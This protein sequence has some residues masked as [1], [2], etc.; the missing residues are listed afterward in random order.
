MLK[1]RCGRIQ[2]LLLVTYGLLAGCRP[3][4]SQKKHNLPQEL[5]TSAVVSFENYGRAVPRTG[6]FT[7][8]PEGR[9]FLSDPRLPVEKLRG[10][11]HRALVNTMQEKGYDFVPSGQTDFYVGY[12]A[13]LVG[14]LDDDKIQEIY[15][16][17]TGSRSGPGH[18]LDRFSRSREND[19]AEPYP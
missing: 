1:S 16:F 8:L 4:P 17:D 14:D 5:K 9:H 10:Y 7:M 12:V 2:L 18:A 3:D 15:G 19:A 11:L 6:T 13:A